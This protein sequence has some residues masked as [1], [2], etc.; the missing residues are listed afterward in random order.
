MICSRTP[1]KFQAIGRSR[2][3]KR[4]QNQ[5]LVKRPRSR[6]G[7]NPFETRRKVVRNGHP[8]CHREWK[9]SGAK[10]GS[11][12]EGVPEPTRGTRTMTCSRTPGKFQTKGCS[13]TQKRFQNHFWVK[14]S[15]SRFGTNPNETR[16]NVVRN[17]HAIC[18]RE[19]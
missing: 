13:R 8:V 5:F 6:F 16:R 12:T 19:F 2:I 4:F 11:R 14:R 7:T 3:Q 10:Q 18:Y 15:R 17:G 9:A 1:A